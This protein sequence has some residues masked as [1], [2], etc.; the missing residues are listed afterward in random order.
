MLHSAADWAVQYG[1]IAVLLIVAGDGVF[2]VLPGETALILGGVAASQDK[3]SL[4]SIIV[5]GT[6]GAVIGDSLAYGAGRAGGVRIRRFLSRLAGEERILAAER[7]VHRRGPLLVFVGRFLPG[8]RIAI[9]LSCGASHMTYKRFLMF[10]VL[11]AAVWST[12]A[13]VLGFVFGNAFA[14]RPWIGLLIAFGVA[15]LIGLAIAIPERRRVRAEAAAA[16]VERGVTDPT[17]G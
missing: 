11:G 17:A 3:L 6:V 7:M 5:A 9:N 4:T 1:W 13:T 10:D 2:P 14:D 12:Q 8:I 15:G 16:K